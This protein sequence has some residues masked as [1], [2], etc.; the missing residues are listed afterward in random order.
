[1]SDLSLL[2]D[3]PLKELSYDSRPER[4]VAILRSIKP[5]ETINDKPAA[6]F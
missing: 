4:D 6:E 5:L 2:K 3:I 1:M